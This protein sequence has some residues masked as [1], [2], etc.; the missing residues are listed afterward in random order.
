MNAQI[1]STVEAMGWT[2]LHFL[3]QGAAVAGV[4]FVVFLALRKRTPEARY[5]ASGVAFLVMFV[6]FGVTLVSHLNRIKTPTI[7]AVSEASAIEKG[8]AFPVFP[9]IQEA[10]TEISLQ[11][12]AA[13]GQPE[14]SESTLVVGE[15]LA[16]PRA[17]PT[18]LPQ[19]SPTTSEGVQ[20]ALPWVVAFWGLGVAL[21][22]LRLLSGWLRIRKV[23]AL[24]APVGDALWQQR[25]DAL[26]QRLRV[27]R[28]VR[29]LTS[30]AV[31]VP[32]V[33][34]WLKPVVL[35]PA[36]LFTELAPRQLEAILAHE[37]AHVRRHDYL[38]NLL[39]NI[40][41]TIFFFHPA[42]WW[43]SGQLRKEREHCCDDVASRECGGAVGYARALVAL[44]ESRGLALV[45]QGAVSAAGGSLLGRV[46][47][48]LGDSPGTSGAWPALIAVVLLAAGLAVGAHLA[49]AAPD[50]QQKEE[51]AKPEPV[52][53]A[54]QI[55][56]E[57]A[58]IPDHL[59]DPGKPIK[60]AGPWIEWGDATEFG[61]RLGL[62][63][64]KAGTE[65]RQQQPIPLSMY[66]RNDSEHEVLITPDIREPGSDI[67]DGS[68]PLRLILTEKAG[69]LE[70]PISIVPNT[71]TTNRFKLRP[72]EFV[73]LTT[74]MPTIAS[75]AGEYL[76]HLEND[77]GIWHGIEAQIENR[78]T[79]LGDMKMTL[80]SKPVKVRIS[81]E[82]LAAFE[83]RKAVGKQMQRW[84]YEYRGAESLPAEAMQ[85][86][87]TYGSRHLEDLEPGRRE[88][89][90][91]VLPEFGRDEDWEWDEA[92]TLV[93]RLG[94][95]SM[96]SLEL[97]SYDARLVPGRPVDEA[98]SEFI[99]TEPDEQGVRLGI[100]GL[101][102]GETIHLE[103]LIQLRIALRNDGTR[104]LRFTSVYYDE[105]NL[106]LH[107]DPGGDPDGEGEVRT[108]RRL[109]W[110]QLHVL[111][112]Y[113]LAPG[114]MNVFDQSNLY[115][116][117]KGKRLPEREFVIT[118]T[119]NFDFTASVFVS[120]IEGIDEQ[121]R[122][123]KPAAEWRG[124]TKPLKLPIVP[125]SDV[126]IARPGMER[127]I[128]DR[129]DFF[130]DTLR[131][132]F[133][134]TLIT[135]AALRGS[136]IKPWKMESTDYVAAWARG[137]YKLWYVDPEQTVQ[138]IGIIRYKD[139]G[140]WTKDEL[141]GDLA[142]MPDRIRVALNL[143]PRQEPAGAKNVTP[144]N[145]E[146]DGAEEPVLFSEAG[147]TL[148]GK[149]VRIKLDD[150]RSLSLA[151]RKKVGDAWDAP[152]GG[153]RLP[154]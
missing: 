129:K 91:K 136:S 89:V 128:V 42:V 135:D 79:G 77:L 116:R 43:V 153:W 13:M 45:P 20:H 35:V 40:A 143:P 140:R 52:R 84:R 65:Y 17:E 7:S 68:I 36:G 148:E 64:V 53:S 75:P 73:K 58:E 118:E 32:I 3:W 19:P 62:A 30:T 149:L 127:F 108:I 76:L 82:L 15:T 1:E 154:S 130:G 78:P 6:M 41:E 95:A 105:Q 93:E 72:N 150:Q 96:R 151:R 57:I 137:H 63:G 74:K 103:T 48:L 26:C 55:E 122:V 120:S 144:V 145:A 59:L 71:W 87:T 146:S 9:A 44:E 110:T 47:R 126:M 51:K 22:S 8:A 112:R 37:L 67:D 141:T 92:R 138:C 21:L 49:H 81:D 115:F 83:L 88:A 133:S 4:L 50:D 117:E 101:R 132:R 56:R 60:E 109:G 27:S 69:K 5:L 11:P 124:T 18:P 34:G 100:A 90:E 97:A 123:V 24:A 85:R 125:L 70:A 131:L 106:Q 46:R 104:R 80:K 98:A 142:G 99:W 119:G 38:V 114:Q 121:G 134:Q 2:L 107:L 31:A 66:L 29:L 16:A 33:V 28:P 25:F 94:E 12:I 111:R 147:G 139:L 61:L 14:V 86:V 10:P 23:R 39:Q 54:L 152:T 113:E 102:D